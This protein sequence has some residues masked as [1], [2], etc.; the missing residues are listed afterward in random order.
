MS[1]FVTYI[2]TFAAEFAAALPAKVSDPVAWGALIGA[3]LLGSRTTS[4][5]RR[6]AY[7]L[8][9][10]LLTFSALSLESVY[11]SSGK[12]IGVPRGDSAALAFIC[13]MGVVAGREL[14]LWFNR[15]SAQQP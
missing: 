9:F 15:R 6:W 7:A 11:L 1:D 8:W 12:G 14:A 10:G 13:A 4:P 3:L 5:R 2:V